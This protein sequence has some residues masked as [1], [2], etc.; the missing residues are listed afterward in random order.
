MFK[1]KKLIQRQKFLRRPHLHRKPRS[2]SVALG[3]TREWWNINFSMSKECCFEILDEIKPLLDPKLNC[4]YYRFLSAA[5]MLAIT[6]Y[7]LK[8]T[9][10]L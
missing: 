6:L 3:T 10:S 8:D 4:P 2:V 1:K 7:Y 5:K 9:G